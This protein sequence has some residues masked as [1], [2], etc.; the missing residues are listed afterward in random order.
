MLARLTTAALGLAV[1]CTA[2]ELTAQSTLERSKRDEIV[3]MGDNDPAMAKAFAKAK[4]T[5]DQFLLI[6]KSPAPNTKSY[7]VKVAISDSR[8]TEYF[9]ILPFTQE[10]DTFR[11]Q[12]NNTP[13]LVKHVAFGQE[14]RFTKSEIVDWMYVDAA[15]RRMHGNFTACALMTKDKPEDAERARRAYGL[16]CDL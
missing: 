11:G 12:L 4:T 8:E 2:T 13:R 7:A 16:E 15:H 10:G 3:R 14:I 9:W 5:L 1:A 6:A